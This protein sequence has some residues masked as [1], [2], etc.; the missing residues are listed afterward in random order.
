LKIK[1]E[2]KKIPLSYA[3]LSLYMAF[4]YIAGPHFSLIRT[5]N[6]FLLE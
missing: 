5:I 3:A 6:G 2:A 4:F 1:E